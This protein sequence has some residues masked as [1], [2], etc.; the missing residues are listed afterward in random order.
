MLLAVAGWEEGRRRQA[1][2]Q[3]E[4]RSASP[5]GHT[6]HLGG[7]TGRQSQMGV[8]GPCAMAHPCGD[9]CWGK[10]CTLGACICSYRHGMLPALG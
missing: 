10:Q 8:V 4:M 7:G 3:G 2:T 5:S 1:G 9:Q 6:T